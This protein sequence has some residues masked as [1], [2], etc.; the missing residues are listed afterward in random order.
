MW[1]HLFS[2]LPCVVFSRNKPT[3]PT[4]IGL[5]IKNL[6]ENEFLKT[7]CPTLGCPYSIPVQT[8][9]KCVINMH[10]SQF[11]IMPLR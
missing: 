3:E 10:I 1:G 9:D 6:V 4:K 11:K 5:Q 2:P 8:L 7:S